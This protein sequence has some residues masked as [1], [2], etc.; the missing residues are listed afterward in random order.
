MTSSEPLSHRHWGLSLALR[1]VAIFAAVPFVLL[2]LSAVG[3]GEGLECLAAP[4]AVVAWLIVV[5]CLFLATRQLVRS[6]RSAVLMMVLYFVLGLGIIVARHGSPASLVGL[7]AVG[8]AV[9]LLPA[10]T[11]LSRVSSAGR[12]LAATSVV[13]AVAGPFI[14]VV[15]YGPALL[16]VRVGFTLRDSRATVLTAQCP[17]VS[18]NGP[19]DA[20]FEVDGTLYGLPGEWGGEPTQVFI[21]LMYQKPPDPSSL[22]AD[23]HFTPRSSPLHQDREWGGSSRVGQAHSGSGTTTTVDVSNSSGSE[24][25][26]L[27]L[28]WPW[29][30]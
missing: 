8:I 29:K 12:T 18:P 4:L 24:H 2:T 9:A 3:C 17:T 20:Q 27:A 5:G 11:N 22:A 1:E 15:N 30:C 13:L 26:S 25:A 28:S 16:G 19:N 14:A 21:T 7:T 23:I 6:Q 10:S